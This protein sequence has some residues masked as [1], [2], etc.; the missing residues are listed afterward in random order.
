MKIP[1]T[2][3]A[4]AITLFFKG[5]SP[6]TVDS[7]HRNFNI[8]AKK[9]NSGNHDVTELKGLASLATAVAQY[10]KSVVASSPVTVKDGIVYYNG[11]VAGGYVVDKIL[12]F[13]G[14]GRDAEP[15]INFFA[16][17]QANP[18]SRAVQ[19]LYR[20]LEHNNMPLTPDGHVL[21]Y[22][23]VGL[24]YFSK[25]GSE[26]TK[27]LQGKVN[28]RGQIYN[29]IGETI[30]VAREDVCKDYNVGCASGCHIGTYGYALSFKGHSGRLLVVQFDPADAVSVPHDCNHQKLRASKYVVVE[31][32]DAQKPAP[33]T[34]FVRSTIA[35]PKFYAQRDSRGKFTSAPRLKNCRFI[36]KK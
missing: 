12:E 2:Q 1:F 7:S 10:V 11:E 20:F 35:T 18:S 30:E 28:A 17:L 34:D 15:L 13:M 5:E 19:E 33:L 26:T 29:G 23:A 32:L 14:A 36:K 16:R 9:L 25:T 31:E 27:V 6:K 4:T 22:K 3:T 24:D 21:G 8:L